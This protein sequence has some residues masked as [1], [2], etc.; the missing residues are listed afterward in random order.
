MQAGL[1]LRA[2]GLL[3]SPQQQEQWLVP[4]ARAQVLGAFALTGP[5][6]GSDSVALDTSARRTPDGWVLRGAKKWIGNGAS[7]ASTSARW[8][9]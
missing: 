5:E 2:L 8:R 7:G 4:L 1:A 9:R 6:H 3:G